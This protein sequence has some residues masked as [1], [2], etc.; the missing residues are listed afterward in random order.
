[1]KPMNRVIL[2]NPCDMSEPVP[3]KH[4]STIS[5]PVEVIE[6]IDNYLEEHVAYRSRGEVVRIALD[7]MLVPAAQQ[8]P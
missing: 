8:E 3:P 6:M 4:W 7:R 1:M 2:I 5:V